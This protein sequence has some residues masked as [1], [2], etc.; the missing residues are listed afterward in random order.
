MR[1]YKRKPA[2]RFTRALLAVPFPNPAKISYIYKCNCRPA[3]FF[4]ALKNQIKTLSKL[5]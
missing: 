5:S 3:V 2:K 1:E 4:V